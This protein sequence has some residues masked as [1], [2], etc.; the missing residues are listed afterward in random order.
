MGLP[1]LAV[2]ILTQINRVSSN[3]LSAATNIWLAIG[4]VG[5]VLLAYAAILASKVI[6]AMTLRAR[7]TEELPGS[8]VFIS[9]TTRSQ[10][11][12]LRQGRKPALA[13][14][15]VVV[16]D[17]EGI[18]IW[19]PKSSEDLYAKQ[20]WK[21]IESVNISTAAP[22]DG[23]V[24]CSVEIKSKEARIRGLNLI[25]SKPG[26][27]LG[28]ANEAETQAVISEMRALKQLATGTKNS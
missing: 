2:L 7:L 15:F 5:G 28:S 10:L 21:V 9:R 3:G 17:N 25:P 12:E 6:P 8:L 4:G 13:T 16:A 26:R 23:F 24:S 1:V 11:R 20:P 27:A 14:F 19:S 22:S 18:A